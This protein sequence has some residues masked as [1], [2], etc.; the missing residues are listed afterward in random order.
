MQVNLNLNQPK[1]TYKPMFQANLTNEASEKFMQYVGK[2]GL[3]QIKET[4]KPMGGINAKAYL[5]EFPAMDN[6]KGAS[7][8][9]YIDPD[10]NVII[11]SKGKQAVNPSVEIARGQNLQQLVR[12]VLNLSK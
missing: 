1:N 12:N 2:K 3:N 7:V 8:L 9:S 10:A 6:F 5:E 11:N 4:V